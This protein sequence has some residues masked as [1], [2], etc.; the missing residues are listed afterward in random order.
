MDHRRGIDASAAGRIFAG[1]NVGTI[2]E[3]QPVHGD[4]PIDRR[5]HG[6]RNDQTFMVAHERLT[7]LRRL[8]AAGVNP[9]S[10]QQ[11]VTAVD[12]PGTRLYTTWPQRN[13]RTQP[14]AMDTPIPASTREITVCHWAASSTI[15]GVK[16]GCHAEPGQTI[17]QR[18]AKP[19]WK[20]HEG[21]IFERT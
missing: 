7:I 9:F 21:L 2:I 12:T 8:A 15:L 16:P 11:A 10:C 6:Q 4:H 13:F 17:V 19:A 1:E 5:I 18:G 20:K 3:C 14:G